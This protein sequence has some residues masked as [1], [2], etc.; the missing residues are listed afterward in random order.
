MN[1]ELRPAIAII[2]SNTLAGLG[3]A[4]LIGR[5]M[6]SA[7]IRRFASFDDLQ[8]E[9][10]EKFY[11]Y[12]VST[13][14]L[15]EH[16]SFFLRHAARTIVLI[17]GTDK[18]HLPHDFHTLDVYQSEELLVRDFLQLAHSA[19]SARGKTPEAVVRAQ[20]P[21]GND[22]QL[23]SREKDVLRGIVR[24]QTNKE[25]AGELNI[26]PTTVISHR[27]HLTE[28]LQTRSVAG[29]AIY[30]VMHGLVKAEE[31]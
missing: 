3:L 21:R 13:R 20:Q 8:A 1:E 4:I 15:L 23:T 14:I 22:A 19:H 9:G 11:H 5:M 24:G 25:I 30:A 7:E 27:K 18:G 6:P 17:H 16:V 12:F 31:I 26:T 29:L 28:K 2:V 10:A